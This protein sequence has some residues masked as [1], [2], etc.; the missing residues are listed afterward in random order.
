LADRKKRAGLAV[1]NCRL[2]EILSVKPDPLFLSPHPSSLL[3]IL[4]I[5]TSKR[6]TILTTIIR[7]SVSIHAI[8]P[9]MLLSSPS[10]MTIWTRTTMYHHLNRYLHCIQTS[11][12]LEPRLF[13]YGLVAF[14]LS[15]L[16]W[17]LLSRILDQYSFLPSSFRYERVRRAMASH[18]ASCCCLP[19]LS[20]GWIFEMWSER[21]NMFPLVLESNS[22]VIC[23]SGEV[24]A[25]FL[26]IFLLFLSSLFF[27]WYH[28]H[29]N[30][31]FPAF[32]FSRFLQYLTL[33][34]AIFSCPYFKKFSLLSF[35]CSSRFTMIALL[36]SRLELFLLLVWKSLFYSLL[37]N[38]S[39]RISVLLLLLLAIPPHPLTTLFC[40]FSFPDYGSLN[41]FK[42]CLNGGLSI[43][44]DHCIL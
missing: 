13:S 3:S 16:A 11:I 26:C 14:S 12:Q 15:W 22:F 30:M 34:V 20:F 42:I 21:S 23:G 41:Y 1:F 24:L 5:A 39:F 8:L 33:A 9:Y 7:L 19:C 6:Q 2:N 17:F 36:S 37:F 18:I 27:A 4:W 28:P 35:P 38:I 32:S 25:I 29:A 43:L 31:I 44:N 10:Y 40:F